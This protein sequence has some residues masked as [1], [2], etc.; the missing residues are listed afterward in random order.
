MIKIVASFAC[1]L[2]GSVCCA[3]HVLFNSY[4]PVAETTDSFPAPISSSA[5][6]EPL[7]FKRP[8]RKKHIFQP[9]KEVGGYGNP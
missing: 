9:C 7:K 6:T 3:L 8:P 4:D 1:V 2:P 5:L